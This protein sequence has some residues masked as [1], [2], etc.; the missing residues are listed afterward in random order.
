MINQNCSW[1]I[2]CGVT[3][4]QTD[5]LTS[6]ELKWSR[7]SRTVLQS[8]VSLNVSVGSLYDIWH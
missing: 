5:T 2:F 3:K 4:A 1:M 6:V 8:T 7:Q